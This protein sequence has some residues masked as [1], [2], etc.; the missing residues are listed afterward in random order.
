MTDRIASLD[1]KGLVHELAS[2]LEGSFIRNIYQKN[3]SL[4]FKL[5]TKEGKKHLLIE[6]SRRLNITKIMETGKATEL[7]KSL[8]RHLRK[9]R[10]DR[11]SQYKLDRIFEMK[12]GQEY[13]VIIE[14]FPRGNLVVLKNEKIILAQ[15]HQHMR[16]RN[17]Y[18]GK[19]Y[20]YPPRSPKNPL[21]M[22]REEFIS[23]LRRKKD[24]VRGLVTFFGPKYAE[25]ICLRA[26]IDKNTS[27]D[28]LEEKKFSIILKEIENII[29]NITGNIEP[30]VYY[31]EKGIPIDFTPLPFK[32]LQ[33]HEKKEFSHLSEA[34]EEFYIKK[35]KKTR[36]SKNVKRVE[37]ARKKLLTR[38]KKQKRKISSFKKK[39]ESYQERAKKIYNYLREINLLLDRIRRA[40][41][42]RDF[43]WEKISQL[44]PKWDP[45]GIIEEIHRDG[46][47]RI[48][49]EGTPITLNIMETPQERAERY[50]NKAK[51]IR[52][53]LSRTENELKR[54]KTKL[55]KVEEE[56]RREEEKE[57]IIVQ[58]PERHWFES[59]RWFT[60]SDD[61]LV[62]AGKNAKTNEKLIKSHMKKRDTLLHAE[63]HG[64]AATVIKRNEKG[65]EIPSTTMEEAAVFAGSFSNA[66]KEGFAGVDVYYAP[67][68]KVTLSPPSG[69][70]LPKGGFMIKEKTYLRNVK[71]KISVGVLVEKVGKNTVTIREVGGPPSAIT[72]KTK[73]FVTLLPGKKQKGRI[74]TQIK[75]KLKRKASNRQEEKAIEKLPKEKF[76]RFIPG[77][78]RIKGRK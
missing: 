8:R 54:T 13:R 20:E 69:E 50:F 47:I 2:L 10:I 17:I 28:K 27:S 63:V 35:R 29:S 65:E 11:I 76:L 36:K 31:D 9:R 59:F 74:A 73:L 52:E 16:D 55:Q 4:L 42:E 75:S 72:H 58:M 41:K 48:K 32:S 68:E 66:W 19:K 33:K 56:V 60:S 40:K 51:K 5:W 15:K 39:A 77:H 7:A 22:R 23:N 64:G 70:Y 14:F 71:L 78:S 26:G 45:E 49:V 62:I 25:E 3:S 61:F 38:M 67:A 24:L 53:R 44:V 21:N 34:I 30:Q 1:L 43:S 12:V 18:P 6:P 57:K 37:H 46:N